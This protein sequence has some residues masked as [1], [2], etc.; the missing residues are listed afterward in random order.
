MLPATNLRNRKL[1]Y[2]E[3]LHSTETALILTLS[4]IVAADEV[5]HCGRS[6]DD[7]QTNYYQFRSPHMGVLFSTGWEASMQWT[8]A[9][10]VPAP[11]TYEFV[12]GFSDC[13]RILRFY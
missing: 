7:D 2:D 13:L 6:S 12:R 3:Q 5:E 8:V 11:W 9:S 1:P 10:G 4:C